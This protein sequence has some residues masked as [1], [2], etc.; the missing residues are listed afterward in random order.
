MDE[1]GV[2]VN[3][4]MDNIVPGSHPCRGKEEMEKIYRKRLQKSSRQKEIVVCR[5]LG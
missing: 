1:L 4:C 5:E 2:Q 3:A